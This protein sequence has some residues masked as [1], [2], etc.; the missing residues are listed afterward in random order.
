MPG[1]NALQAPDL[2]GKLR[3]LTDETGTGE[4]INIFKYLPL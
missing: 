1:G 2:H 3:A 4:G